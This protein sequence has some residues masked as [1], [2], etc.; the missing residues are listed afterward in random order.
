MTARNPLIPGRTRGHRPRLQCITDEIFRVS[1][2]KLATVFEAKGAAEQA[3]SFFCIYCDSHDHSSMFLCQ[4]VERHLHDG[5]TLLHHLTYLAGSFVGK[6]VGD[7]NHSG[8]I[9]RICKHLR[10]RI[11]VC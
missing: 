4:S 8:S 11:V 6:E 5:H 1:R 10:R 7:P 2:Q 3:A 9:L